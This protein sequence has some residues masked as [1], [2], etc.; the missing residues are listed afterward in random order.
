MVHIKIPEEALFASRFSPQLGPDTANFIHLPST[1]PYSA[2]A[3][4]GLVF[5]CNCLLTHVPTDPE[6]TFLAM[7]AL[8]ILVIDTDQDGRFFIGRTIARKFP[9]VVIVECQTQQSAE[10]EARDPTL[11]AII[12]HKALEITGPE[13]IS[14]L[15][16]IRPKLP[17][18]LV[19]SVDREAEARAVGADRFLP[20]EEWLRIG[21]VLQE[22]LA[23]QLGQSDPLVPEA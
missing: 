6:K 20:F 9:H 2:D 7:T 17:M 19:S 4:N 12:C 14:A 16:K 10:A 5:G 3:R 8:R 22:L 15:R 11:S 13:M 1:S 18:I 21:T 23:A